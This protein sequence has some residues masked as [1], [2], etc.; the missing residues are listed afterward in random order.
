[1]GKP[2]YIADPAVAAHYNVHPGEWAWVADDN[3]AAW[4]LANHHGY[5]VDYPRAVPAAYYVDPAA[6]LP[7]VPFNPVPGP[8]PAPTPPPGPA[9]AP[10]TVSLEVGPEDSY[11]T[12]DRDGDGKA[13][14]HIIEDNPP[15]NP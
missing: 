15:Q 9:P 6:P 14:V 4:L 7:F 10:F 12:I 13:D 5:S 2:I 11:Q 1:M 3:E 8:N